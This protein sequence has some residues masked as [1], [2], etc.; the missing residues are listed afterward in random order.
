M[1][2]PWILINGALFLVAGLLS[3]RLADSIH[4][5]DRE[6]DPNTIKSVLSAKPGERQNDG[7]PP[8]QPR[9]QYTASDFASIVSQ[10]IFSDSRSNTPK[11]NAFA[12]EEIPALKTKPYL[13]GV[14]LSENA[15]F[16]TVLDPASAPGAVPS[17]RRSQT[18]RLGDVYQ[19]YTLVD[20]TNDQIVLQNGPRSEVI[21]LGDF[22]RQ[23]EK[24]SKTPLIATR[25]VG[26]GAS[27]PSSRT[28]EIIATIPRPT[29]VPVPTSAPPAVATI[30]PG[31]QAV[32]SAR[33]L[34][35]QT[36]PVASRP[37]ST[38]RG[39]D[40]QTNRRVVST[41]VGDIVSYP[42]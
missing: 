29:S 22:T 35:G 10:N 40:D 34:S 33:N 37:L 42:P 8:L 23:K 2:K 36:V 20:I 26:F 32:Q 11:E 6:N 4:R 7:L 41:A 38:V 27:S 25:V 30:N 28:V 18:M 15:S 3:W 21:Q 9:R 39:I 17:Q 16:V 1:N 31:I 24:G 19:G 14:M 12:I 13:L 5:F